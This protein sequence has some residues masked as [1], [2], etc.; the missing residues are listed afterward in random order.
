LNEDWIILVLNFSK[1][2]KHSLKYRISARLYIGLLPIDQKI[3]DKKLRPVC[4]LAFKP[5]LSLKPSLK[6]KTRLKSYT[7]FK[8]KPSLA[9][10]QVAHTSLKAQNIIVQTNKRL[11]NKSQTNKGWNSPQ[12]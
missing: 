10:P 6:P 12:S 8:F 4:T 1:S 2:G 11:K 7:I 5:G 9:K 3:K